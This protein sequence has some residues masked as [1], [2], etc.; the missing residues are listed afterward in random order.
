LYA[1]EQTAPATD[2]APT[3]I[4]LCGPIVAT[5]HGRRIERELPGRQGRLLFVF[6]TLNRFRPASRDEL[7]DA[8]WP[9]AA[10][11]GSDAS[12]NAVLSR[13]RRALGPDALVGRHTVQLRL[14]PDAW[15]DI[16]AAAQALHR[17][18]SALARGDWREAWGA[19]RVTLHIAQRGFLPGEDAPWVRERR[20][21]LEELHVRSLEVTAEAS[22]A[23]GGS[24]LDTAER[25]ARSLVRHA[26]FRD[27][28]YRFLMRVLE[29]RG[30]SAEALRV[31]D[32]LR[33]LLRDE[34]GTAPSPVTQELHK[35][36]LG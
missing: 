17:A 18:E 4:Q 22:L 21:T 1:A 25:C 26:P 31:Y 27:S 12:L 7:A 15:I 9:E 5:L 36:L 8:L 28:G 30:N 20:Q 34:L 11:P 35:A 2:T 10:P 33:A 23:I 16:E 3:R 19:A 29:R 24:E 6:L 32:R 14:A 13:L